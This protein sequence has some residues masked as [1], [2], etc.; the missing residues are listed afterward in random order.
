[1]LGSA[2]INARSMQID[3]ELNVAVAVES[4]PALYKISRETWG[5][6]TNGNEEINPGEQ[7]IDPLWCQIG[8]L[9]RGR[10]F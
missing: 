9:K 4:Q 5:W 8:F 2:N 3:S 1:M 6:H 7:L 10:G